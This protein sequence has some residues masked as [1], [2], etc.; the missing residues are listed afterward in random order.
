MCDRAF[1]SKNTSNKLNTLK[2][3]WRE[4]RGIRGLSAL[5]ALLGVGATGASLLF[6]WATKHIVD[7]ATG[8][9]DS[10]YPTAVALMIGALAMQLALNAATR[11]LGTVASARFSCRLRGRLFSHLMGA[12]WRGRE[13]FH[14]ADSIGRLGGDVGT[15]ATTATG[16]IPSTAITAVQLVAA[17][18]FLLYLDARMAWLIVAIMPV[19]L[20][21]SKLYMKR[22]RR[23]TRL[24]REE[25]TEINRTM[26]ESLRHRRLMLSL[27]NQGGCTQRFDTTQSA[28]YR[29]ILQRNDIS[30]FA[31]TAVTL[32]FMAGYTT[33]F[34]WCANGLMEGTVTFG[35]MTAFLQLV[36][37]VQRPVVD[38]AGKVPQY[39]NAGVAVERI[40]Q[41]TDL[42]QEKPVAGKRLPGIPGLRMT[43]VT[44]SYPDG[45]E[46]P[47]KNFTHDFRPG[48]MTAIAGNTGAGKTTLLMIAL[49][50]ATPQKGKVVIYS[51]SESC[52]VGKGARENM[53]YV[54]QGNSL[55][56]GTV[57]ENLQMARGADDPATDSEMAEALRDACAEFVL[58]LPQ[59]LDSHCGEGG[60]GFSE[61]EAQRIAVARGL[62]AK[63]R[64]MLLDEPTSAL[65][66]ATA[67]RLM[68]RLRRE[69]GRRTVV[70]VTHR[71]DTMG[72]C[73]ET[74]RL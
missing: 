71:A 53:V 36:G 34:L 14:T 4:A 11:R 58:S 27:P 74:V 5:T 48:S 17:F 22:A 15:L 50:M 37:Q 33:A 60:G 55:I 57:R 66:P 10:D 40:C 46:S 54:P 61:G 70:I 65:D 9:V 28:F 59:G 42:P 63:A 52:E 21:L 41:L 45:K 18:T 67:E 6:V 26:Q 69:A 35:M 7:I 68:E 12:Q 30:I 51:G 19:A 49:G 23:L 73:D 25:E 72:M 64:I 13:P 39:V 20:G 16:T 8:V 32:G 56:S 24:I 29:L 44:Y 31:S 3:I 1:F 47:V 38:L 2:W 43:D 62:L